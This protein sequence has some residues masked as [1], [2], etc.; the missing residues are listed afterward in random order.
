LKFGGHIMRYRRLEAGGWVAGLVV[1]ACASP[2]H[3]ETS[4]EFGGLQLDVG[5]GNGRIAVLRS[6]PVTEAPTELGVP[7]E[8]GNDLRWELVSSSGVPIAIGSAPDSRRVAIEGGGAMNMN[9]LSAGGATI[10]VEIPNADGV[11]RVFQSD[12]FQIGEAPIERLAGEAAE[13]GKA[14]I[15]FN[16]DLIGAPVLVAGNGDPKGHFNLLFVPEGF[17]ASEI[18]AFRSEVQ[19]LADRLRQ[20]S[21]FDRHF[22]QLNLWRQDIQSHASGVSDPKISEEKDKDTAFNITW[23]DDVDRPRRCLMPSDSWNATTMSS[24][25]RLRSSVHADV[26]IIIANT[27]ESGGCARRSQGLIVQSMDFDSPQTLAH[28]LG[29]ALFGV[30]DE[31]VET[32]RPCGSGPNL[33]SSLSSIPWRSKIKRDTPI[34]T[35]AFTGG[36]GAYEGGGYCATGVWRPEQTCMMR[37]NTDPFCAVC[38]GIAEKR[39]AEL[40]PTGGLE[41]T[42]IIPVR[43]TAS[44]NDG[45]LPSSVLD[46]KL[47]TRWS[48]NKNGAFIDLDLG[49]ELPVSAVNI[50]WFKGDKRR[51][52]YEIRTFESSDQTGTLVASGRSTGTTLQ[53]ERIGF[54]TVTARKVRITVKGNSVNSWASIAEIDAC[55]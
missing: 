20:I 44:G 25:T 14:D 53:K 41:C 3:D 10:S 30:A 5:L 9:S 42:K 22:E 12:G 48:M 50:A 31:Y 26:T 36:V 8:L 19:V 39:F 7:D 6:L 40:G 23:G 2:G 46:Q 17:Q 29:H 13:A 24:L 45:N 21:V 37:H 18:E 49:T 32:G 34:P 4:Q 52:N 16:T 38:A 33:T 54:E 15:D 1:A 35:P 55:Q 28:E 51:S 11:L 47:D 27:K 43:A